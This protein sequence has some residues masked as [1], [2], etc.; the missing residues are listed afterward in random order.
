MKH[1]YPGALHIHT[2]YSDGT[3]TIKEIARAA[4]KADLKWIII[5]D[6][7]NLA[8]LENNEEDWY[9]GVAVLIG[10]EISPEDSDHY[11]AFGIKEEINPDIGYEN[12][13]ME[14][15]NQGGI[16]F[17]AH[18][19]ESETRNNDLRPLRWRDWN[20]KGFTGIEIWNYLSDLVDNYDTNKAVSWYFNRNKML[21]G[22]TERT[23]GWWDKVNNS[24]KIVPAV[25]GVDVHALNYKFMGVNLKIFPYLGSLK[26]VSNIIFTDEQLSEDFQEA[27]KQILYALKRGNNIIENRIWNKKNIY[28]EFYIKNATGK[29]YSG[30]TI[31]LDT[32]T[33]AIIKISQ[34]AK[35]R[36]IHNG[37]VLSE[38]INTN[39]VAEN[40]K[41]GKYRV[42]V[43][44][45]DR[46]WIFSNP[47]YVIE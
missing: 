8:G 25:A 6:H 27:K 36:L 46:P 29:A 5:T 18:P 35:I 43:Y 33:K 40:L 2:L 15:N 11:L 10:E 13:I 23:L 34:K 16:G 42:E 1:L 26:T 38:V 22:P 31:K 19:D 17:I 4:K 47:V 12:Y 37:I 9:D 7:N 41:S 44:F 24:D 3:G 45:K 32:N 14:V 30:E 20:V 21:S 39:L 28:P